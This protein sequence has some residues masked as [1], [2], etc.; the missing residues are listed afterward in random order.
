MRRTK[1][2]LKTG[3]RKDYF[4]TDLYCFVMKR[5]DDPHSP[6]EWWFKRLTFL[7]IKNKAIGPP[8]FGDLNQNPIYDKKKF[9][10]Q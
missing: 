7:D 4:D 9:K 5:F 10:E 8:R 3:Y 2:F 1:D 6:D